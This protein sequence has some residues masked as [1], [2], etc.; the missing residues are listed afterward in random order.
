VRAWFA[1]AWGVGILLLAGS[2]R[3]DAQEA[4]PCTPRAGEKLGVRFVELCD[5][6]VFISAAPIACTP[7]ESKASKGA[8]CDP[9]T[10]LEASSLSGPQKNRHV[11]ARMTEADQA[12]RL[13]KQRVGGRLPTP[14]ERELARGS[15]GLVSL[16]VR[17]EP[18]EYARLRLDEM[19]EWVEERSRVTR[20]LGVKAHPRHTGEVLLA[21][22]AEPALPQAKAVALGEVCDERPSE[23]GVRSPNCAIALPGGAARFE[24]GCDTEHAVT[25][26][27]GPEHAA[28]RCVLPESEL[29]FP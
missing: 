18:G 16:Q 13:C 12:D 28:V 2:L 7:E 20:S 29:R 9:V 15:L 21:C 25:S 11:D 17:E 26:R 5:A 27:A 8:V 4:K 6:G 23:G 10:A 3:A 24:L 14:R 19:P 22:V 1:V